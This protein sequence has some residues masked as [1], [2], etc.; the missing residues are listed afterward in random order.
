MLHPVPRG[1]RSDLIAA[2]SLVALIA[3]VILAT[4]AMR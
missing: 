2:G 1:T 4:L 3:A